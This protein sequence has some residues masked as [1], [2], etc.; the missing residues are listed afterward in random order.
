METELKQLKLNDSMATKE[1][2]L[3]K[4]MELNQEATI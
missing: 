2:L 3:L 1:A 4:S